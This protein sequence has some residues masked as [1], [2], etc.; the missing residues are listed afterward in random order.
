[1]VKTIRPYGSIS[2]EQIVFITPLTKGRF[3]LVDKLGNQSI[4]EQK[5]FNELKNKGFTIKEVKSKV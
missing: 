5:V 4:I 2:E 3:A 1:M